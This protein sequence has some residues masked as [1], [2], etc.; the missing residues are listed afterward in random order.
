MRPIRPTRLAA[1]LAALALAL[2]PS[3]ARADGD[4]ASDYLLIQ[5]TFMP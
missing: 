1:A 4:P 2:V 3:V 5:D